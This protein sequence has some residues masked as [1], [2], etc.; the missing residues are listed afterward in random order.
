[1]VHDGRGGTACC[2]APGSRPTG[3]THV[4]SHIRDRQ[5]SIGIAVPV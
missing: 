2:R 3:Y 4:S 5:S 1:M